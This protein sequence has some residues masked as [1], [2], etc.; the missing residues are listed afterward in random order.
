MSWFIAK[1]DLLL[2]EGKHVRWSEQ[3]NM[4]VKETRQGREE[5]MGGSACWPL[6]TKK[7]W[8]NANYP[9]DE[10]LIWH[11]KIYANHKNVFQLN[12]RNEKNV[13]F[14]DWSMTVD[15]SQGFLELP[16]IVMVLHVSNFC[17]AFSFHPGRLHPSVI[18]SLRLSTME[19]TC[20]LK[21]MKKDSRCCESTG[22]GITLTLLWGEVGADLCPSALCYPVMNGHT[23]A[24]TQSSSENLS[25][26]PKEVTF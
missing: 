19:G 3:M 26:Y 22:S 7:L 20:G 10:M 13:L 5:R 9:V 25:S 6:V 15:W 23:R 1:G 21:L 4:Q 16:Q 24:D 8:E 12:V 18:E 14:H 2:P 11:P 17:I